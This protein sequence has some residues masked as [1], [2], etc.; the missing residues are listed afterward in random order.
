MQIHFLKFPIIVLPLKYHVFLLVNSGH[1]RYKVKVTCNMQ[2]DFPIQKL[3]TLNENKN[4]TM[5]I[6]A[7]LGSL[8]FGFIYLFSG[9]RVLSL[10]DYDAVK[11]N[12][13]KHY[14]IQSMDNGK[15][16]IFANR[17]FSSIEELVEHYKG[18][19][20]IHYFVTLAK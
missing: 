3:I 7:M 6:D 20:C 18:S 15:V 12:C 9:D 19:T 2:L 16:Y 10:R 17:T 11:G 13:V 14:K 4:K 8:E 1:A 5:F